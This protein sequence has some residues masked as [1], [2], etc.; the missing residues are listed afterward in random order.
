MTSGSESE[1][2][3]ADATAAT[4]KVP[5]IFHNY[6]SLGGMAITL[7]CITSMVL[8]VMI[9][10]INSNSA[11]YMGILTWVLVP[12][13][14]AFGLFVIG[15]GAIIERFRRR[16]LSI[17]EIAAYPILDLSGPRRRRR[18]LIFV[19]VT[20]VFLFIS[21][22]ASYAAFEYTESVEFC[23]QRCH[24]VM[25]PEFTAY[26]AGA[27]ARV[28]CVEC[29][30]GSGADWYVKSKLS[31]AY[32]L[33][34]VA[35]E[36]YS[37]PITTPVH[38]MRPAPDTCEQCHWPEKFYGAQLKV[39]DRYA[40][41]ETNTPRQLRM[42]INV[43]GGTTTDGQGQGIHWHMNIANEVTYIAADE[44]RQ[45]IPWVRVKDGSGNVTEYYDRDA[46]LSP[47]QLATSSRRKMDCVDCHNRP[48]HV[49]L[50]PDQAIDE[51]FTA[52][53]MDPSLPFL[54]R[55]GV[56][57]LS[58]KYET[59][60]EALAAI[61]AGIT[62]FYRTN[63]PD[64]FR[65][66]QESV[67]GSIAALQKIY[68]TYFFPE[69]RTD[70]QTHPN[71]I[72]HYNFAGC[73][74]CH[75]GRHVSDTGKVISNDCNL[76]HTTLYDSQAPADK[77]IKTGAFEH[78][79]DLGSLETKLCQSCHVPNR[80]FVHPVDLGDISRFQC[81]ECHPRG[82]KTRRRTLL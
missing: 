13:G 73:F 5:S 8:L 6:V 24:T 71:N 31:G 72:G 15:L 36:K 40:Y 82:G 56:A 44:Q 60:D 43:G 4:V 30:V 12:A 54:K 32:Q 41:D 3:A 10:L 27:H 53:T 22:F 67:R 34:S 50:P 2:N 17:E 14:L 81:V 35:F 49:Y 64:V 76:C 7:A 80:P 63:Y 18:F 26:L 66:K 1:K 16:K 25:K 77:N 42:L 59:T 58:G 75:D 29:H 33:Y 57:M 68:Q 9:S 69:M 47:E 79:V 52:G 51:A 46:P 19:F 37:R 61:D 39:F 70:W 21:G 28:R 23:G 38:G 62:E 78:P 48:A 11:P 74:R 45:K 20:F 65:Q 55:Q